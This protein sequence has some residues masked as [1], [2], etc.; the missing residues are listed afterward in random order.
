MNSGTRIK[1]YRL[2]R[3]ALPRDGGWNPVVD[4]QCQT[5]ACDFKPEV[6]SHGSD[7]FEYSLVGRDLRSDWICIDSLSLRQFP[8]KEVMQLEDGLRKATLYVHEEFRRSRY[9]HFCENKIVALANDGEDG[10]ESHSLCN[11]DGINTE[12]F[13]FEARENGEI[14]ENYVRVAVEIPAINRIA[15]LSLDLL[16]Y[17]QTKLE[18]NDETYLPGAQLYDVLLADGRTSNQLAIEESEL[19]GSAASNVDGGWD[20]ID[21]KQNYGTQRVLRDYSLRRDMEAMRFFPDVTFNNALLA[22]EG[23]EFDATD[24][25]TWPRFIRVYPYIKK[26]AK[27]GIKD[28]PNPNYRRAPFGIST[29]LVQRVMEVMS[30]PEKTSFGSAKKEGGGIGWDGTVVWRN[31]DWECNVKRNKGFFMMCYRM[32]ARPNYTEDGF[33]YFHRLDSR[34]NIR[35]VTCTPASLINFPE[36]TPYC[37]D[38]NDQSVNGE[39][40]AT[41]N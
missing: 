16:D 30:F 4:T 10:P 2:G 41:G 40:L 23:Y 22:Q 3:V 37:F 15:A 11:E 34:F 31:P 24:P 19:M 32:S 9:I 12:G 39:N 20:L 7:D 14:N 17:A 35:A 1:A 36:V 6:I 28:D 18:Y 5:N 26:K 25:D 29:I 33:A 21:L 38:G 27:R 13:V 8:E